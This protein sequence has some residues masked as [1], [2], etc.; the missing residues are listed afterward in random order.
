ME[1]PVKIEGGNS[2]KFS[3]VGRIAAV[4]LFALFGA[5]LVWGPSAQPKPAAP[6]YHLLKTVS[7][8]QAPG[9]LE[10]FDYITVDAEARRVYIT[11]GTEVLVLNADDYT[12]V[13]KIGPFK[14]SHGAIVVKSVGKGYITDGDAQKVYVFDPKTLKITGEID[15]KYDVDSLIYEP[16]TKHVFTMNAGSKN[17]TVIDPVKDA[18]I[19]SIDLG[20]GVEFPAVDGKGMVYDNG[21]DKNEV[22][23]IDARTNKVKAYWP[24]APAASIFALGMDQKNGRIFSGGRDPQFMVMMDSSTG[25]VLQSVKITAGVDAIVYE[26]STKLLFA[27]T[28][29]GVV[30]VY[31][32]DSLNMITE[33]ETVKTQYGAKTMQIDPKT[34]NFFTATSDFDPPAAPTEKQPN[35]LPRSKPGNFRVLVYGR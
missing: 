29:E 4:S 35:P 28:R 13:G 31:H 33:V 14:R 18:V 15:V 3:R 1:I 16:V 5:C 21:K 20:Q 11:H 7:L 12:L 22:I 6:G 9:D 34:H 26:P 10:Y 30:H 17:T 19:T 23:A 8:P 32:E 27:S 25:K 2:M 24:S